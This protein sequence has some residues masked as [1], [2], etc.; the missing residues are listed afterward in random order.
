MGDIQEIIKQSDKAELVEWVHK[1][2][3]PKPR[4]ALSLLLSLVRM[5]V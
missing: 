2:I 1:N 4:S 5:A 3:S